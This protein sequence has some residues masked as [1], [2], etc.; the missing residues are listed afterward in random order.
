[1]STDRPWDRDR[2]RDDRDRDRDRDRNR[3]RDDRHDDDSDDRPRRR[4]QKEGGGGIAVVGLV[5]GVLALVTGCLTGIPAIICSAVG[6]KYPDRKGMA[7]AGLVLG[8]IG[9]LLAAPV[10][11]IALLLPAVQ[12]VRDAAERSRDQNSLKIIGIGQLSHVDAN[13][14]VLPPAD[15]NLS[16]R[17]ELLPYIEQQNLYTRFNRKEPWNSPTNRPLAAVKVPNYTSAGDGPEATDTRFRVFT[18]PETIFEPGKP[19]LRIAEITDGTGNTILVAEAA[20]TVPWPQPNELP[21]TPGGP[22]P[23][24]GY[25]GRPVAQV[26]LADGSVRP[27]RRTVDPKVLRA[28]I[29]ATGGETL[30]ADWD[31]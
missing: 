22:L 9:T 15:G 29:T 5:L 21:Y 17:V 18:G 28:L 19:P 23:E 14:G 2:D 11:L 24:L 4:R 20:Q 25:P 6:M 13:L 30:P 3:D 8:C 31:R 16:W 7:V 1:M 10:L 12:K 26:L 27:L